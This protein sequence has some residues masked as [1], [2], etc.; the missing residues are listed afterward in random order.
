MAGFPASAGHRGLENENPVARAHA[1]PSGDVGLSL[2]ACGSIGGILRGHR[3]VAL[4]VLAFGMACPWEY[5]RGGRI[6][7]AVQKEMTEWLGECPP[8]MHREWVDRDCEESN[9]KTECKADGS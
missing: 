4:A 5:G 3:W 6:D 9:C 2:A 1:Q 7:Q 8:G